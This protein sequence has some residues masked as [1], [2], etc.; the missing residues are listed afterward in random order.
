M[1]AELNVLKN[2]DTIVNLE[3]AIKEARHYIAMDVDT[4]AV[5]VGDITIR[6]EK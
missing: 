3:I 2:T 5:K 6:R 4:F 1:K